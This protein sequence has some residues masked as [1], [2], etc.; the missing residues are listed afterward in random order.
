MKWSADLAI[1]RVVGQPFAA[2][3]TP[4]AKKK[5]APMIYFGAGGKRVGSV[6]LD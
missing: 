4:L 6:G 2:R 3:R 1:S 5:S